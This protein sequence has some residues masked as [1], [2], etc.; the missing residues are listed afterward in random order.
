[1]LLGRVCARSIIRALDKGVAVKQVILKDMLSK[2]A[3]ALAVVVTLVGC[4]NSKVANND[5]IAL[6]AA[7]EAQQVEKGPDEVIQDVMQAIAKAADEDLSFY[8]PLHMAKVTS[9]LEHAQKLNKDG[10][11]PEKKSEALASAITAKKLLDSAYK[12]KEKVQ[13]L[14]STSLDHQEVLIELGT[15]KVLPKEYEKGISMMTDV[16]KEVEGGNIEKVQKG[17][18]KLLSYFNEIEADTLRVKWLSKAELMLDKAKDADADDFAEVSYEK[19][20]KSVERADNFITHSFR[21]RDGVKSVCAQAYNDAAKA[22]YMSLEVQKVFEKDENE[23]EQYML[24]V[25]ALFETVNSG[26]RLEN[27]D[28]HAFVDQARMLSEAINQRTADLSSELA[29]DDVINAE[30]EIAQ[31]GSATESVEP[32]EEAQSMVDSVSAD[33]S[34]DADSADGDSI[35]SASTEEVHADDVSSDDKAETES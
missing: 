20:E 23:V 19:A 29:K 5:A 12:N 22:Y 30:A 33:E 8:A 31:E 35:E 3:V 26:I 21:D 1:M 7:K 14:L 17:Q 9:A 34:I 16:I 2:K 18:A 4:A 25:Q 6:A 28:S 27:I 24:S 10:A 15:D 11:S 13:Q 32:T